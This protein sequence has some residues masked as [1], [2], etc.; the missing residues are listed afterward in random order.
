VTFGGFE[1]ARA[2][3]AL[4]VVL[5]GLTA[6]GCERFLPK[7]S[8]GEQI[9]RARCAECHGFDGRGNTPRYMGNP[10]A[11]LTRASG[12]TDVSTMEGVIREGVPGQ[13]RGNPDL[14][15]TEMRALLDWIRHLR[16]EGR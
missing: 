5:V 12:Y 9:Y 15:R 1:P 2:V 6:V 4:V 16:G 7:R 10:N 3:A 11:D 14:T 13:M 8:K